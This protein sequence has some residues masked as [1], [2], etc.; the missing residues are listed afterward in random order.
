MNNQLLPGKNFSLI[1]AS[2]DTETNEFVSAQAAFSFIGGS[3]TVRPTPIDPTTV[4]PNVCAASSHPRRVVG[5]IGAARSDVSKSVALVNSLTNVPQISYSSTNPD[6]SDKS[7]FPSFCRVAPSDLQ[8]ARMIISI[9]KKFNWRRLSIM[10]TS[11]AYGSGLS[12]AV[13]THAATQQIHVSNVQVFQS[14]ASGAELISAL[15]TIRSSRTR[16]IVGAFLSSDAQHVLLAAASLNM[17]GPTSGYTWIGTDGWTTEFLLNPSTSNGVSNSDAAV[18]AS[19]ARGII[20]S[21]PY[22]NMT[23]FEEQ[24]RPHQAN[25]ESAFNVAAGAFDQV[26]TFTTYSYEAVWSFARAIHAT[27][28]SNQ[29]PTNTTY[30]LRAIRSLNYSGISGSVA[31]TEQCD[32]V[33]RYSVV[34]FAKSATS[35]NGIEVRVTGTWFPVGADDVAPITIEAPYEFYDGTVYASAADA[36]PSDEFREIEEL[37]SSAKFITLA[38]MILLISVSGLVHFLIHMYREH[39]S[40]KA[41][42]PRLGHM[43]TAGT[44]VAYLAVLIQTFS[45]SVFTQCHLPGIFLFIS[46]AMNY[47]AVT[48]R[49]F[50]IHRVFHATEFTRLR[51]LLKDSL[52]ALFVAILISIDLFI[53][54]VYF[55]F[56]PATL[57]AE[58]SFGS[59]DKDVLVCSY[60]F[61]YVYMTLLGVPTTIMLIYGV[62]LAY[63]TRDVEDNFNETSA[64]GMSLW[65]GVFVF[66]VCLPVYI[67]MRRSVLVLHIVLVAGVAVSM[68]TLLGILYVP[69]FMYVMTATA[70]KAAAAAQQSVPMKKRSRTRHY[71]GSM[72][73]NAPTRC[74]TDVVEHVDVGTVRGKFPLSA[75]NNPPIM[76]MEHL[77]SYDD[78]GDSYDSEDD[79]TPDEED[80]TIVSRIATRCESTTLRSDRLREPSGAYSPRSRSFQPTV[81]INEEH[82]SASGLPGA[83]TRHSPRSAHLT[84]AHPAHSPSPPS[85]SESAS[86]SAALASSPRSVSGATDSSTGLRIGLQFRHTAASDHSSSTAMPSVVALPPVHTNQNRLSVELSPPEL[87]PRK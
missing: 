33:P 28:Q 63:K 15:Q 87:S 77:A 84:S 53:G 57:V 59:E 81:S 3:W 23:A 7:K 32:R 45:S 78:D 19:V 69:R 10:A 35:S 27:L 47:G 85:P 86:R 48:A 46:V 44:T 39:P 61:Y 12:S 6:L 30:L 71:N 38:V 68:L 5:T 24:F 1:L 66:L 83:T 80:Y 74:N 8:Q 36:A 31:F 34:N 51:C 62:V 64:I 72:R 11:S 76:S 82:S 21:Q 16:I 41:N 58:H 13:V 67:T 73:S 26:D 43:I 75:D 4:L 22:T 49:V 56:A 52:L 20:G 37:S 18:L 2:A 65:S 50:R 54:L 40:M 17:V 70:Q 14:G 9:A 42:S 25:L 79:H 29:R 60:D 55:A